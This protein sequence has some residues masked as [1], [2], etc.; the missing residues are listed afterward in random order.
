MKAYKDESDDVWLFAL[1]KITNDS[2]IHSE[3]QCQRF[4]KL[5]SWMA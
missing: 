5:F 4:L 3:W 2:T 1:M